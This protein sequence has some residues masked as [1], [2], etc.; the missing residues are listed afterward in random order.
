[1][2]LQG[3][4]VLFPDANR[5]ILTPTSFNDSFSSHLRVLIKVLL[6]SNFH[7]VNADEKLLYNWHNF[8]FW[9]TRGLENF[10][11]NSIGALKRLYINIY[12][13]ISH[14]TKFITSYYFM[15]HFPDM[16]LICL[17]VAHNLKLMAIF[18]VEH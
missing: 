3:S 8:L 6:L 17:C 16:L 13:T 18:F 12:S 11:L 14:K 2:R 10:A 4:I 5:R 7:K 1:M 9:Q 15:G